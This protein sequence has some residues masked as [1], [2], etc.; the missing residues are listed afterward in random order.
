MATSLCPG[1][2]E[3]AINLITMQCT[4]CGDSYAGM[5]TAEMSALREMFKAAEQPLRNELLFFVSS[6]PEEYAS[7]CTCGVAKR[8]AT[9]QAD[10][11]AEHSKKCPAGKHGARFI[12]H[13]YYRRNAINAR[14]LDAAGFTREWADKLGTLDEQQAER[15][16]EL[17]I[18]DVRTRCPECDAP[19][20][21]DGEHVVCEPCGVRLIA[22]VTDAAPLGGDPVEVWHCRACDH[23]Y[24]LRRIELLPTAIVLAGD[25]HI[26]IRCFGCGERLE[27]WSVF[28]PLSRSVDAKFNFTDGP[29]P[30]GP[31][32]TDEDVAFVAGLREKLN[33]SIDERDD[34]G[35]LDEYMRGRFGDPERVSGPDDERA[36]IEDDGEKN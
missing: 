5:S 2:G 11:K 29:T 8:R 27:Q 13:L 26:P 24:T 31:G 18:G 35:V 30:A 12:E 10:P 16:V 36:R 25:D 7:G 34:P 22:D 23:C 9:G 4:R 20:V 32:F 28:R 19:M 33:R 15:F 14:K 17:A 6:N 3:H 21:P 1:C